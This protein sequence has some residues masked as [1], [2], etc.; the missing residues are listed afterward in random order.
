VSAH[1]P[2]PAEPE[3]PRYRYRRLTL[4][5]TGT[6]HV[7]AHLL[8]EILAQGFANITVLAL[9]GFLMATNPNESLGAWELTGLAVFAS[10]YV[11][12]SVA[13]IQ[14]LRFASRH[15]GEVCNVGVWR[16]SRHPNYFGEWL[17]W[18]GI[19]VAALPSWLAL[20]DA[21]QAWVWIGLGIGTLGASAILY[22]TLVYLTGA[23]P[24]EYFSVRGRPGYRDYQATTNMF[25]P[26]FPKAR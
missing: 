19:V 17:V 13:D 12:E 15:R 21:E 8:V 26:W 1:S 5:Q 9:P 2:W 18:T 22:T 23:I 25:F 7:D 10:G 11:L 24:A 16:F 4:E 14:K 3:F 20:R 6:R